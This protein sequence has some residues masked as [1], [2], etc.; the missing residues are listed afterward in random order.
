MDL[1]AWISKV[2]EGHHLLEGELQLLCENV[3]LLQPIFAH[4]C[5]RNQVELGF[6]Y[7][8]LNSFRAQ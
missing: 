6:S 8:R 1:D 2:K 3:R 4:S 7:A 5:T